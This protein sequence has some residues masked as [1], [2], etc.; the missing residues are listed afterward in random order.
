MT[1]RNKSP[2]TVLAHYPAPIQVT[3]IGYP[4]T[5]GFFSCCRLPRVPPIDT[6]ALPHSRPH[7]DT[8]L[9][10]HTDYCGFP[11]NSVVLPYLPVHTGVDCI[12]YRLVDAITDPPDTQQW[13]CEELIRLPDC[14][15]AFA[16][17]QDMLDT[18]VAPTPCIAK[19]HVAFGTF[20][21]LAKL[22][23]S[24]F[25]LWGRILARI[26]SATLKIKGMTG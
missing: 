24:A 12:H 16:P 26:P 6:S 25:R 19:G 21:N 18:P 14:F 3:W 5:S 22:S 11:V 10:L 13:H 15:L 7:V 1:P 17:P 2:S 9:R 23:P 8:P 4:N 20:N